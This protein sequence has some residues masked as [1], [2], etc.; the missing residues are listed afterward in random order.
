MTGE[1]R[2][3]S[4]ISINNLNGL[5]EEYDFREINVRDTL[6]MM[7]GFEKFYDEILNIPVEVIIEDEAD[8]NFPTN[9]VWFI[10]VPL[11]VFCILFCLGLYYVKKNKSKK[12]FYK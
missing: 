3:V 5:S 6:E 1:K 7:P 4:L 10:G 9:W 8:S 11:I 2:Q 12:K